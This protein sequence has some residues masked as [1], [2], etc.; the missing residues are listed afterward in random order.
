MP[1]GGCQCGAVGYRVEGAP[2]HTAL[3][4]C[5][6]CRK[7]AGAP[8]VAWAAFAEAQ[9]ALEQGEVT[10]FNSSGASRRSFCPKCGTGEFFR[11]AETLPGIIDIQPVT[12]GDPESLAPQ[13]HIQ[14]AERLAYMGTAHE[15]AEFTR[16]PGMP[17]E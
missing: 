14:V 3:C 13:V 11:N 1:K 9:F 10:T 6:D 12:P 15:L 2:Q 8:T 7:S 5:G 17:E 4:H 16:Y